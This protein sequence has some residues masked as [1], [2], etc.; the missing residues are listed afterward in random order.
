M[1]NNAQKETDSNINTSNTYNKECPNC[2]KL[3]KKQAPRCK[4]CNYGIVKN[5]T[6]NLTFIYCI[7]Q[8]NY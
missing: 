5:L 3:I 7:I 6:D 1:N 2:G 4:Y 8:Q